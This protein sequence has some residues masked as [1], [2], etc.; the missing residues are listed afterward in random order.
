[1]PLDA[2]LS[3][4]LA[5]SAKLIFVKTGRRCAPDAVRGSAEMRKAKIR[6]RLAAE[7][8]KANFQSQVLPECQSSPEA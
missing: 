4:F 5:A 2:M 1:M 8:T 6:L 3:E 7:Q